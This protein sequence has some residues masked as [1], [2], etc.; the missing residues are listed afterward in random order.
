[1]E[2][3]QTNSQAAPVPKCEHKFKRYYCPEQ[4]YH[5]LKCDVCGFEKMDQLSLREKIVGSLGLLSIGAFGVA[6]LISAF[7]KDK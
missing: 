2:T 3:E 1:M 7:L 5:Y 6:L 4:H